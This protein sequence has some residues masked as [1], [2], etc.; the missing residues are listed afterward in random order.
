MQWI[1]FTRAL[2]GSSSFKD[3]NSQSALQAQKRFNEWYY[4]PGQKL[5]PLKAF[6]MIAANQKALTE[7]NDEILEN[8]SQPTAGD[9]ERF[10][11]WFRDPRRDNPKLQNLIGKAQRRSQR[12]LDG[13]DILEN[14]LRTMDAET[15]GKLSSASYFD[16][17]RQFLI[18]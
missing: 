10:L 7:L 5:A 2:A 16:N 3:Q 15:L 13:L 18:N 8:L 12:L 6:E 17:S 4:G 11:G 9:S 1:T 14:E